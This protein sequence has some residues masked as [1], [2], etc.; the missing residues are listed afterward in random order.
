MFLAGPRGRG[1]SGRGRGGSHGVTFAST[2]G[3]PPST[4]ESRHRRG[5]HAPIPSIAAD[6]APAGGHAGTAP[7]LAPEAQDGPNDFS[8]FFRG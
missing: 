4:P 8:D 1:R 3:Y 5:T 7:P 6:I 2:T